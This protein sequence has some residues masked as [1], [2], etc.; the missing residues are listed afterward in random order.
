ML[1]AGWTSIDAPDGT[2]A[3]VLDKDMVYVVT[4]TAGEWRCDCP[5]F[6]GPIPR[7]HASAVGKVTSPL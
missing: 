6:G 4:K 2:T 1:T 3:Q 5:A 7:A